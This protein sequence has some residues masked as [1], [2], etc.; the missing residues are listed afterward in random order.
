MRTLR[1]GLR[2]VFRKDAV[3][4]DLDDE[5]RS[6]LASATDEYIRAGL[7]P[8]QAARRARVELGGIE[9]VKE[10]ARGFG[11]EV[12]VETT[13]R[14]LRFGARS[15]AR[16]PGFTVVTLVTLALGIG[17]TTAIFSAV[18]PILFD[19]LPYPNGD[20][21]V[22]ISYAADDG[23]RIPQAFGTFAELR[24][25]SRSL[26]AAAAVKSWLPTLE[27]AGDTERLTGQRVSAG[28]LDVLGVSPMIGRNFDPAEDVPAGANEALLSSALWRRR[29]GSDRTIV[30]QK[31]LLNG[32]PFTVIGVMAPEFEN[33]LAPESEIWTLLQYDPALPL[34]GREWGHHLR[35][36]ARLSAQASVARARDELDT[37]AHNPVAQFSRPAWASMSKGMIVTSLADDMTGAVR[38]ALTAVLAAV[39]LMLAIAAVNVAN[40][41][42]GRTFV[43][44]GEFAMRTAL[45]AGR[46]RLIRQL[47]TECGLLAISGAALG[48]GVA[49]FGLRELVALSPPEMPRLAAVR[50]DGASLLFAAAVAAVIALLIGIIPVVQLSRGHL[51]GAVR[52][53]GAR[54]FGARHASRHVLV[55]AEVA[56]ALVLLVNAGLLWRSLSALFAVRTGFNASRLLTMQVYPP[57]RTI[58]KTSSDQFFRASLDAVR[59]L[60][61]VTAAAFTSQLPLSGDDA[62]Y[63]VRFEGEDANSGGSAFRYAVSAGYFT[64]LGIPIRRGRALDHRD[65]AGAPPAAIISES[66]AR[67]QFGD[68]DPV[69]RKVH[70]GPAETPWFAIVGVAGDVRQM[71]LADDQPDAVYLTTEQSWFVEGLQSLVVRSDTRDASTL[72]AGVKRAIHAI[73]PGRPVV[74]VRTM[75][76]LIASTASERRFIVILLEAFAL[77]ALVL[78][79]VGLHGVLSSQ[80]TERIREIGVRS[81]LGAS[82]TRIVL[83]VLGRGMTLTAIGLAIGLVVTLLG[84]SALVTLLFGVTR[85]DVVTYA[86]VVAMLATVSVI[87]C[88]IPAWRAARVDPVRVLRLG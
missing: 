52:E 73:D 56:L 35:V 29:F 75:E 42:S 2:R 28:Y 15:L 81:A 72:A 44:A 9:S 45:G 10:H 47:L 7:P 59:S 66:L 69:G 37:I 36:A 78:A 61:G 5:V 83:E 4:R 63:G 85:F 27:G 32:Q 19:P 40:L 43:R 26:S 65:A 64:T 79:S 53:S 76:D 38:P 23:S 77:V 50:L 33:V 68:A 6:Y 14:D 71:S 82:R 88:A 34:N 8:D 25:R 48:L 80:V 49:F 13:L 3:E 30:G 1:A 41:V 51:L 58:D 62:A 39:L 74:R 67:R 16:T 70:I 31:I 11:W 24:A 60:S 21:I 22:S 86:G 87:A 17:A 20:A 46:G 57:S 18:K 54:V 12:L 84:S 55:I